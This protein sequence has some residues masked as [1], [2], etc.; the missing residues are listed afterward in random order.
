MIDKN[1]YSRRM[2]SSRYPLGI[3]YQT[4]NGHK[5]F[6]G[7]TEDLIGVACYGFPVGRRVVGFYI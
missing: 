1:H 2:S 6:D 4:D 5:F 3:F 7:E